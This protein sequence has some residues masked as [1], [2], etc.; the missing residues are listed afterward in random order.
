MSR[1]AQR[2]VRRA[3]A[4]ASDALRVPLKYDIG[5]RAT[6]VRAGL[7]NAPLFDGRNH[8]ATPSAVFRC[9]RRRTQLHAR[10]ATPAYRAAA[11]EPADPAARTAARRAAVRAQFAPAQAHGDGALLL[12]A[13]G[14]AARANRRTRID[15]APRRQDRA[16]PVGRLRRLD[17]VRDAAEDH[18]PLSPAIRGSRAEACT[19]CRR[20]I[21]SRR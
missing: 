13:C 9:G 14:A 17:A 20:W 3:A 21:R 18:P 2:P 1:P 4:R 12:S 7:R 11:V 15:D 8:G 6:R 5:R 16:Q 10:R 19:R